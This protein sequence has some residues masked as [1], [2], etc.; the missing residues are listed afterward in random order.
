M[1]PAIFKT[2]VYGEDLGSEDG[3]GRA[4]SDPHLKYVC[5]DESLEGKDYFNALQYFGYM[6]VVV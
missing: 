5:M 2:N 6:T 4:G 3:D 1:C